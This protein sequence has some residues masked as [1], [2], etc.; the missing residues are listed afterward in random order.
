[1]TSNFDNLFLE[2]LSTRWEELINI[3]RRFLQ[4]EAEIDKDF[5]EI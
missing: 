2:E 5:S 4:P 1:M 3:E